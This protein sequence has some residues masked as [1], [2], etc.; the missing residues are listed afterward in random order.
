M[1]QRIEA[2]LFPHLDRWFRAIDRRQVRR[3]RAI[4]HIPDSAHRRG[5]KRSYAEWGHVAGLFQGLMHRHLPGPGGNRILDIGCGTGLLGI[6]AHPLTRQGGGYTGL[7]VIKDDIAFCRSHYP[8]DDYRFVH[9]DVANPTYASDQAKV[10][11]PWPV[12]D[13]SQDLVTAL[14]VWTHLDEPDAL[15]YFREVYRVLKPGR[16][17][18]ITFFHLDAAYEDFL[19]RS[20]LDE[21]ALHSGRRPRDLVFDRAAYGSENWRCTAWADPPEDAIGV[22]PEGMKR[23]LDHA[24]L[25]VVEELPGTWKERPG[26]YF[27]DV[28]VLERPAG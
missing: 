25:R 3:S 21:S 6:A 18:I 10:H 13:A 26:F 23:L 27:Q 20:D 7:D 16:R 12:D 22:T 5:G 28:L 1:W 2:R 4:R 17:A 9:L 24:G 14:S 11:K 15:Y 19:G 8:W